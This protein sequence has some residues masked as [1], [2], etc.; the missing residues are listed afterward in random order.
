MLLELQVNLD[1]LAVLQGLD[2]LFD[3]PIQLVPYYLEDLD[4]QLYPAT[5]L[6]QFG[7]H[8][9]LSR[10][11]LLVQWP[12]DLLVAQMVLHFLSVLEDQ[13]DLSLLVVQQN[14]VYLLTPANQHHL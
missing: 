12:L 10:Q 6:G 1:L 11:L 8:H 13:R 9:L 3:L 5:L 4:P 2:C 7:Q 14:L